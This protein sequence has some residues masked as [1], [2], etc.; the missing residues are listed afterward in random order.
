MNKWLE[1]FVREVDA[2]DYFFVDKMKEFVGQFVDLQKQFILKTMDLDF[3]NIIDPD[4]GSRIFTK[5]Q[6][7]SGLNSTEVS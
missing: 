5:K 6:K 7:P 2:I 3:H 1:E 4:S